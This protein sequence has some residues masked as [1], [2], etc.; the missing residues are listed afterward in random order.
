MTR[1]ISGY[2]VKKS[3]DENKAI[4][5]ITSSFGKELKSQE[6]SLYFK[7][8]LN[9]NKLA[10]LSESILLSYNRRHLKNIDNIIFH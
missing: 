4:A 8:Y 5:I 1:E 10:N 3:S 7:N 6:L 2:F 9:D